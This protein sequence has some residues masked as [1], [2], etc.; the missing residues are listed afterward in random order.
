MRSRAEHFATLI[1]RTAFLINT[2][3]QRPREI[4]AINT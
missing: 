3:T 4:G 1:D 2:V